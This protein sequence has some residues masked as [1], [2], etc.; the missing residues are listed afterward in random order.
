MIAIHLP[1]SRGPRRALAAAAGLGIVASLALA[2]PAAA[3]S[4]AALDSVLDDHVRHGRVDYGALARDRGPLERYLSAAAHARPDRWSRAE[5]IAFWIDVY[6]ARVLD[7]VLRRPGIASV[8]DTVR[9]P[10]RTARGFF[11]TPFV[12][13]GRKLSLNAIEHDILRARFHEPRIH[14]VLTCASVSCP[15]LFDRAATA[16]SLDSL[17]DQATARFLADPA[18]NRID[19][20]RG[21]E[22]SAIFDWYGDDFRAADGTVQRFVERHWPKPASFAPNLPVRFLPYDWKL[23]GTW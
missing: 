7:G 6:N 5:Q 10:G 16:A 11:E 2:G 9:G 12:A 17:L 14:F 3:F 20:A 19:P 22:L 1:R 23:N 13:A 15:P 4:H 18:H 21:L 8:L